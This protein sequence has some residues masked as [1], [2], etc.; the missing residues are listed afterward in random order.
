[1]STLLQIYVNLQKAKE[2]IR[3]K[4][5]EDFTEYQDRQSNDYFILT[6]EDQDRVNRFIERQNEIEK[7]IIKSELP[8]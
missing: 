5:N 6:E 3:N 2:S 4:T 8:F 1:M 7:E